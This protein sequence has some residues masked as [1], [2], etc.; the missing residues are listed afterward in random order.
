MSLRVI[1]LFCILPLIFPYIFTEIQ[2]RNLWLDVLLLRDQRSGTKVALPRRRL[3]RM[4]GTGPQIRPRCVPRRL[5]PP[6]YEDRERQSL[7]IQDHTT[8]CTSVRN[9][10][11]LA[12]VSAGVRHNRLH[13]GSRTGHH[14][15][16]T[17]QEKDICVHKKE[18]TGER[19]RILDRES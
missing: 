17:L 14:V 13:C 15:E 19:E 6:K 8:E 1:Y 9:Q 16:G 7:P 2:L 18:A 5:S 4:Q 12:T 11:E 10:R 3:R